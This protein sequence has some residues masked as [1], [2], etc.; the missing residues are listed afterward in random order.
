IVRLKDETVNQKLHARLREL[1]LTRTARDWEE[2]GNRAGAAMGW[3]RTTDEWIATDHAREIGA[4]IQL[5]DPELGP[6]WMAG[7]PVHLTASPGAPQ[8]ARHLPDADHVQIMAELDQ[9]SG[10]PPMWAPES[11]LAHP[12]QGLKVVDL[13]LALAGPTCG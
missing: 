1:F 12:L 11:A 7:L 9:L 2:L 5:E 10:P 8:G 4:V 6:T 3:A 13:C